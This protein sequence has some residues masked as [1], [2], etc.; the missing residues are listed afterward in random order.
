MNTPLDQLY[1]TS[2]QLLALILTTSGIALVVLGYWLGAGAA[3]VDVLPTVLVN[4][5]FAVFTTGLVAVVYEYVDR[6]HGDARIDARLRHAI[7]S[8]APAIRDVVLDSFAFDPKALENVASDD[9][10]DRIAANALGLRLGDA[11]LAADVYADVRDQVVQ[12][13]ERWHDAD[14]DVSLGLWPDGPTTGRG[15]MFVATIRWQYKVVPAN[16]TVRF[17][18]VSDLA[19][20][21][22]LLRDQSM[23]S[24]WHFDPLSSVNAASPEVFE[25]VQLAVDGQEKKIRRSE[26]RGA[27]MYSV[28]LGDTVVT[29]KPVTLS[30]TYRVLVQRHGHLLYLDL[31]RPTKGVHVRL[32]YGGAG[33][34]R[35]N[36]LDYFASAQQTR[37]DQTSDA[38][39]TQTV[40][41]GF[42]GWIFP[43]SG[44]AFVWVLKEEIA[45][46]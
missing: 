24:V 38:L 6:K 2:L 33:I 42:D 26:R 37:I 17:A 21:R 12:A 14:I 3:T 13:P 27:Q 32:N 28:N 39:F 22:E 1:K 10:L 23:T 11:N 15:S 25:L 44:V 41:V 45:D 43:R 29:G 5:G 30:Y 40:D 34:R 8:E 31:P 35:V 16:S 4:V 46:Q 9:T 36:T 19:E 18:C 7:R 20:Y